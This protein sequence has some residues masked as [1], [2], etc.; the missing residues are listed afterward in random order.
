MSNLTPK[1]EKFA[2]LYVELGN[3]SEAYRLA[4]NSKAKVESVNVEASKMLK[5]P[6]ISLHIEK[7]KRAREKFFIESKSIP[8][9]CNTYDAILDHFDDEEATKRWVSTVITKAA[10]E[11]GLDL[12][13]SLRGN[14]NKATRYDIL[15][16]A[17]FKCQAC[18]EKPMPDNEV[19][20]HIDHIVPVTIGGDSSEENLQVLCSLC[21]MS[22]GN[23]YAVN[24]NE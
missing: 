6:K 15:S 20:L 13:V 7:L 5:D 3:A 9:G 1:Q 24:H 4:Y 23:R 18:G 11:L 17:G 22:K 16:R 2:Q 8:V 10:I 21:N 14:I 12:T 19:V